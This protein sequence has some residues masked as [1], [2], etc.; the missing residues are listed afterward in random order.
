LHIYS[1]QNIYKLRNIYKR[2]NG[3]R[4]MILCSLGKYMVR[5][6]DGA[7]LSREDSRKFPQSLQTLRQCPYL[8][9]G[10]FLHHPYFLILTLDAMRYEML[11]ASFMLWIMTLISSN[12]M[13][14]TFKLSVTHRFMVY[15]DNVKPLNM[16]RR[17][18]YLKPQ[19]VPRCK[20]FSSRL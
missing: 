12:W 17:Q 5:I 4:V 15:G 8:S 18:F 14:R 19:S 6:S 3:V 10:D 20:H 7:C 2:V 16:K 9:Q 11:I 13:H 1:L